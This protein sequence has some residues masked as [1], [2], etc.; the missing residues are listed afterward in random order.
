MQ[1]INLPVEIL[2]IDDGSKKQVQ[3]T[4]AERPNVRVIKKVNGGV[5]SARN[6][7]AQIAKYDKLAFLDSDDA[8]LKNK[9][10]FQLK[11]MNLFNLECI[12]SSWS[13]QYF[14]SDKLF[15][16]SKYLLPLKWWPHISTII[17]KKELFNSLN[18][19][20]EK[21]QYAEDGDL[22]LKIASLGKL[23]VLGEQLI[24]NDIGKKYKH[25]EGL[26]SKLGSM[27]LGEFKITVRYFKVLSIIYIPFIFLKFIFRMAIKIKNKINIKYRKS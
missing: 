27:V 19:F 1:S 20:D 3:K 4:V 14:Y 16:V 21:L 22:L 12:G 11:V 13:S 2:I 17:I 25:S 26:S 7:G 24:K 10:E 5:S 9:I 6:L 8:W 15:R 23:Y 18:G